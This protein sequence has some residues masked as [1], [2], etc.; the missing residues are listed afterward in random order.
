MANSKYG[1]GHK[2]KY[3]DTSRKIAHVQH[4]SSNVS[5]LEVMTKVNFKEKIGQM[6]SPK[7]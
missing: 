7:V 6:S 1:Q 4:E 2:D 5:N 3:V